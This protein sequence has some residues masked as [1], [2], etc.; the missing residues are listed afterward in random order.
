MLGNGEESECAQCCVSSWGWIHLCSWGSLRGRSLSKER[1]GFWELCCAEC[2]RCSSETSSWANLWICW[3]G[4]A[5]RNDLEQFTR[6]FC[7]K[8]NFML[9]L[10]LS[11][12]SKREKGE[13]EKPLSYCQEWVFLTFSNANHFERIKE[14]FCFHSTKNE[15]PVNSLWGFR[16][17]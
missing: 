6:S 2:P 5:F 8:I 14:F 15:T 13:R 12:L 1:N 9:V 16:D 3:S 7:L 17:F 10:Q 11:C 4:E